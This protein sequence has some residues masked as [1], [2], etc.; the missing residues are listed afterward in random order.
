MLA[1]RTSVFSGGSSC[2]SAAGLKY[3]EASAV[4]ERDKQIGCACSSYLN[5]AREVYFYGGTA[6]AKVSGDIDAAAAHRGHELRLNT[7]TLKTSE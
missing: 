3:V 2:T 6:C 7:F 1:V 5:I 4:M